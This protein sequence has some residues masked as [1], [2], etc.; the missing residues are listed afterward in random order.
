MYKRWPASLSKE[1]CDQ[2]GSS[3]Y[4]KTLLLDWP[5]CTH[6]T[7]SIQKLHCM[8][9]PVLLT[10][11]W[12]RKSNTNCNFSYI[13]PGLRGDAYVFFFTWVNCIWRIGSGWHTGRIVAKRR[14][15]SKYV[16]GGVWRQNYQQM[17]KILS[18]FEPEIHRE[19]GHSRVAH[20]FTT[21]ISIK[22]GHGNLDI[23]CKDPMN[24]DKD[25]RVGRLT[26]SRV[27]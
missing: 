27:A 5:F 1:Y 25:C 3:N 12:H 10:K 11:T 22:S 8:L 14:S 9:R 19:T 24:N 13:W 4:P 21:Y 16:T 17:V 26:T 20:C 23:Q 2:H 15:R 6:L 18:M 7:R